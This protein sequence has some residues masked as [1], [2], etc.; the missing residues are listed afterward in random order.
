[1]TNNLEKKL[2]KP[3]VSFIIPCYNL[4]LEM[5]KE[6]IDSILNLSLEP[7]EREILIIDDGSRNPIKEN[8]KEYSNSVI[9]LRQE[10][11]GLSVSRNFGIESSCGHYIQF[12]DGDD[13]LFSK[14]YDK[15][16]KIVKDSFA[17]MVLFNFSHDS[18]ETD[19]SGIVKET[20]SVQ[21]MMHSN[22]HGSAWGYV[23]RRDILKGLRF[24]PDIFHEDEEFT[25]LLLLNAKKIYITSFKAYFY[26]LRK[27]SIT[28]D[29][30]KENLRKRFLDLEGVISRLNDKA[31]TLPL[32]ARQALERRVA[33][34][35]M[36]YLY[37][38]VRLTF[39]K[40]LFLETTSRLK[41]KNLLPLPQKNYTIYYI[42]F[43]KVLNND[44]LRKFF[45]K[46]A[47]RKK[48]FFS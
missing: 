11:S 6:A 5:I 15:C 22:I 20:S 18:N 25:P 35:T 2:D 30:S 43:R 9:F 45:I 33:Q 21:Y 26:R 16:L 42:I 32:D 41:Q 28:S 8:L 37:N 14:T 19:S 34:L 36:D 13:K 39:S 4:P 44:I 48:T 23:F 12:L 1:M 27:E 7:K 46:F 31:H 40:T 10:N 24:T 17:D 3:L 29:F 38:I 47:L